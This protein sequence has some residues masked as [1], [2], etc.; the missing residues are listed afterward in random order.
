MQRTVFE[1]SVVDGFRVSRVESLVCS[2]QGKKIFAA[3]ADGAITAY[4]LSMESNS[5][6]RIYTCKDPDMFRKP[7]K[8]KKSVAPLVVA[9][10]WRV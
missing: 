1:R 7:S 8:D 10:S 5:A 6:G 9:E 3:T 4:T 2:N